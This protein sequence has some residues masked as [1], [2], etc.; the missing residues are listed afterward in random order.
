MTTW[1]K[2]IKSKV[3]ID[4][5]VIH[6]INV[7]G[8]ELDWGEGGQPTTF[9]GSIERPHV[10]PIITP[11]TGI[12]D[13]FF[14]DFGHEDDG[15]DYVRM[16]QLSCHCPPCDKRRFDECTERV[17]GRA[18]SYLAWQKTEVVKTVGAVLSSAKKLTSARAAIS[19]KRRALAAACKSGE[20]VALEAKD[21]EYG[22][23][24]WLAQVTDT[25]WQYYGT[26]KVDRRLAVDGQTVRRCRKVKDGHYMT[27]R[28]ID[29][30][31]VDRPT[32]FRIHENEQDWEVDAEAVVAREVQLL[33]G[34]RGARRSTRSASSSTKSNQ[35][36]SGEVVLG[37]EELLRCQSAAEESF[38]PTELAKAKAKGKT[39][40][41][42]KKSQDD[43]SKKRKAQASGS[44]STRTRKKAKTKKPATTSKRKKK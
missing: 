11:I 41:N 16:R 36:L 5:F 39:A 19:K 33:A 42:S 24:F 26:A 38:Q 40:S 22:F 29:R 34:H 21:D 14:F 3:S 17:R 15:R 37:R 32:T 12:R 10:Q 9:W 43:K 28:I 7:V 30:C 13:H 6:Y 31:P 4:K 35:Q 18:P 44:S 25:I 27:V 1:Q 2:E 23:T 20:I 8:E